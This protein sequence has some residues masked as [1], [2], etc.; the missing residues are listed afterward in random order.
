MTDQ[1]MELIEDF[2]NQVET[3]L[4]DMFEAMLEEIKDPNRWS[5]EEANTIGSTLT[6]KESEILMALAEVRK[7][8]NLLPSD[9]G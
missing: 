1:N 6:A 7:L 4:D 5:V 9:I 8:F 3:A 2:V